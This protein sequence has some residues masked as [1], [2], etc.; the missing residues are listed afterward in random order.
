MAAMDHTCQP[1]DDTF[2]AV[3]AR[4]HLPDGLIYL[5]GNSLGA[6][7]VA[8]PAAFDQ[9]LRN[10]WADG[11]ITSWNSAGWWQLPLALGGRLAR[12]AGAAPDTV[13]V[14]DSTSINIYKTLHAAL[15]L[16][17][18]RSTIIA[19]AAAFPTD[20][21]M[22]EGVMAARSGLQRRLCGPGAHDL[23]ELLDDDTAVVLLSHVDYRTG[24]ILDMAR[25][26]EMV[27][28]AGALA[29]WDL[30]HSAGIYPVELDACNADFAVGCTYKYLNG[31]P[32]SPAFV[33]ANTRHHGHISQP[34]SGWWA[35]REPFAFEQDFAPHQ[36]MRG[37]L[38]G[39]QP[40]LSFKALEVAL[41]ALEGVDITWLRQRS[42]ML[43]SAF[44]DEVEKNCS[45]YGVKLAG[46]R[47]AARRG[48]QVS[49]THANAFA[50]MQA[51]IAQGVIGD[52]RE[53]D[54]LR[55]GFSPAYISLADVRRAADILAGILKDETW[56]D[57]RF[58]RRS[59]VT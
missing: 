37:F 7:P 22:S 25:L 47:D 41:D 3:R 31:G 2:N 8:M 5:D 4:F 30:C 38:C 29:I 59:A 6:M 42:M 54:F 16:R 26:T 33:Y 56:R 32:G 34:L 45:R 40:V 15:A 19:E 9:V 23:A 24:E 20:L 28:K 1:D 58:N 51:L 21:Y 52:F 36:G 27:H 35:H 48:S 49:L 46:P 50:I 10:E 12:F 11:L 55:F 39:T 53:P 13:A 17:P 44:I 14:T 43:T 57:E 18:D